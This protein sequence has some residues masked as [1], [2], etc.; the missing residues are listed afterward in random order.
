M[1]AK[2]RRFENLVYSIANHL[3]VIIIIIIII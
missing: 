2:S 3:I 1:H